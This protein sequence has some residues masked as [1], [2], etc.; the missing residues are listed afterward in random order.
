MKIIWS[1]QSSLYEATYDN[2]QIKRLSISP[3]INLSTKKLVIVQEMP[4]QFYAIC[5]GCLK[6]LTIKKTDLF[7]FLRRS[8]CQNLTLDDLEI[9]SWPVCIFFPPLSKTKH[10]FQS[11][12]YHSPSAYCTWSCSGSQRNCSDIWSKI[13]P[14]Y[15][16]QNE[17]GNDIKLT[18][19]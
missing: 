17:R 13:K 16:V 1:F 19:S 7:D 18:V 4:Y 15:S 10:R 6:P 8:E 3:I 14:I 2:F 12:K 11:R 5:Q 9:Q